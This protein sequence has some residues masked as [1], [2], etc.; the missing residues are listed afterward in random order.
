M[1]RPQIKP[2]L[3]YRACKGGLMKKMHGKTIINNTSGFTLMEILAVL[4]IIA[5]VLSFAVPAFRSVRF[6]QRNS[7]AKAGVKKLSEAI[8][9]F[10]QNSK[11]VK[12][13]GSFSGTGLGSIGSCQDVGASGVPGTGGET[14]IYQ[15]FACGYLNANDFAG[16]PYTFYSC[17][18]DVPSVCNGKP[19]AVAVGNDESSA[20]KKYTQ[21]YGGKKY[22][23]YLNEKNLQVTDNAAN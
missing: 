22:Y 6:E 4:L 19:Y 12:I 20:G 10:Y 23:I 18:A 2:P 5:V 8:R 17:V 21:N 1:M 3:T 14:G 11:G 7:Q 9:S 13:K 15:L 16:L